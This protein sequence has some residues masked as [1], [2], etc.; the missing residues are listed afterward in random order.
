[1][2]DLIQIHI[3]AQKVKTKSQIVEEKEKKKKKSTNQ[4]IKKQCKE[5]QIKLLLSDKPVTEGQSYLDPTEG[6][7]I[8]AQKRKHRHTHG[9]T[10]AIVLPNDMQQRQELR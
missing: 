9:T 5:K 3:Q 8:F 10:I 2:F 4:T 6:H 1:M 7:T